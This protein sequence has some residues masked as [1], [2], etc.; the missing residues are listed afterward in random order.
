[1]LRYMQGVFF[2]KII[3][4]GGTGCNYWTI[5]SVIR[6]T[7]KSFCVGKKKRKIVNRFNI[8]VIIYGMRIVKMKAVIEMIPICNSND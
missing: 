6:H 4:N 5:C 7:S 8:F 1:M 3:V 2:P